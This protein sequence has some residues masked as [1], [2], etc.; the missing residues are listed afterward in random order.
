LIEP[1]PG[2]VRITVVNDTPE[3]L[4]LMDEILGREAGFDVSPL[5]GDHVTIDEIAETDPDLLLV[6][7]RLGGGN[8]TGWDIVL[9]ARVEDRLREV[10][11]I[12]CSADLQQLQQREEEMSAM[13]DVHI[14]AK[15]FNLDALEELVARLLGR[16]AGPP[17]LMTRPPDTQPATS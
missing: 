2:N 6:D 17:T 13:A 4:E 14:L 15:P 16:E 12:V 3:F 8:P 9:M 10:P 5:H 11:V 7:L 1:R